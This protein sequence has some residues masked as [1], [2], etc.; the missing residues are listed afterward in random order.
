MSLEINF[1]PRLSN[2]YLCPGLAFIWSIKEDT[3]CPE[4]MSSVLNLSGL[5]YQR[6]NP[7][8]REILALQADIVELKKI[9]VQLAQGGVGASVTPVVGPPG[10]AG[11]PGPP[12][13]AG[14][15][16]QVGPPGPPGMPGQAGAPGQA[17]SPGQ[18][19][20]SG[21]NGAPGADGAAGIQ[22]PPGPAGAIG[23]TGPT[24]PPGP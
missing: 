18:P 2:C 9:V 14:A 19:G 8:R 6:S 3:T 4:R 13:P 1:C 22:G 5:N 7:L 15:D 21:A 23:P 20:Q 17:G 24:G 16:G 11:P 12:G 10:P